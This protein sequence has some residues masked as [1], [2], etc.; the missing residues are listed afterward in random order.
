MLSARKK[1]P[2]GSGGQAD[3]AFGRCCGG[4][5][6]KVHLTTDALGNLLQVAVSASTTADVTYA[7]RLL[8]YLVISGL[9][10]LALTCVLVP[11][12]IA[13]KGYDSAALVRKIESLKLRAVIPSRRTN[14]CQ[15]NIDLCEYRERHLVECAVGRLKQNRRVA[16]RY[17]KLAR[18][19]VAFVLLAAARDWLR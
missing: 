3:Q 19:Y 4:F 16:T 15:R 10:A 13:D 12:V 11:L 17:D 5:S 7:P 18:N 8:A 14:R 9:L 2:D 1:N 6:T